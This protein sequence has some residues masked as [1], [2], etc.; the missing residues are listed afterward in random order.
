M[1][2]GIEYVR[3]RSFDNF[4]TSLTARLIKYKLAQKK[5]AMNTLIIDKNRL[6]A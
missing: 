2:A 3:H 1:Y 5:T 6:K 4:A